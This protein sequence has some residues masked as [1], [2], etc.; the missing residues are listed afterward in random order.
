MNEILTLRPDVIN[1]L[2]K[3]H[4]ATITGLHAATVAPAGISSDVATTH[5]TFTSEFNNAL[6]AY[7]AVRAHAGQALQGVA[8]GLS[9]S[10]NKA[11]TAYVNT[12]LNSAEILGEQIDG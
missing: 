6:R 10:L 9:K 12:D 8:A 5:G 3:G 11:L 1:R 7:E 4:D 2:A